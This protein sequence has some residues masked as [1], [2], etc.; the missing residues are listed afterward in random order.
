M[1]D[2]NLNTNDAN[3]TKWGKFLTQPPEPGK[4]ARLA[5]FGLWAEAF[6]RVCISDMAGIQ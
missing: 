5:A 4:T 2:Q 6:A 3:K 1:G